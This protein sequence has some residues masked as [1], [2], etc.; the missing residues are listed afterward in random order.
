MRFLLV[1]VVAAGMAFS[2]GRAG[3]GTGS[4][5]V[6]PDE[7]FYQM[8]TTGSY[9]DGRLDVF[10]WL[11]SKTWLNGVRQSDIDEETQYRLKPGDVLESFA[12]NYNDRVL[13]YRLDRLTPQRADFT[14]WIYGSIMSRAADGLRSYSRGALQ[15]T[16]T[17]TLD[18]TQPNGLLIDYGPNFVVSSGGKT[19]RSK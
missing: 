5:P 8:F 12:G 19:P 17:F 16:G 15:H 11:G 7:K 3:T 2:P 4:D 10:V 13:R 14:R 1:I 18:L 6:D 9:N